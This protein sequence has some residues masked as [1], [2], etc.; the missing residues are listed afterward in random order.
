MLRRSTAALLAVA[1]AAC[2]IKG[3]LKLPPA[4]Q[5][6]PVPAAPASPPPAPADGPSSYLP[7]APGE[8]K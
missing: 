6:A 7:A 8:N 4:P 3:P 1:V 2:G 5:P